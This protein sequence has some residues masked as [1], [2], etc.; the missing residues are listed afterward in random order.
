MARRVTSSKLFA[1]LGGLFLAG[2]EPP[3]VGASHAALGPAHVLFLDLDGAKVDSAA[4][5]DA[6]T[7]RSQL[8]TAAAYPAFQPSVPAPLVPAA[9]V[10]SVLIDRVRSYFL[11]FDLAVVTARPTSG[12]YAALLVGGTPASV[13]PAQPSGVAGISVVDCDEGNPRSLGFV[14]ADA[15][16]PQFGGVVSLAAAIAHEAGHGFGL[17]HVTAPLDPMYSVPQPQQTLDDLFALAFGSGIY[18][19]YVAGSAALQPERC[20][21]ADPLDNRALLFAALGA[22]VAPL[23]SP[24]SITLTFPPPLPVLPTSFP[25]EVSADDDVAVARVEVYRDLELVAVLEQAPYRTVFNLAPRDAVTLT[26]E[27]V[28]ADGQRARAVRRFDVS[29]AAP[30]YCDEA[31]P[32]VG[33]AACVG[34]FCAATELDGSVSID[35]GAD[36]AAQGVTQAGCAMTTQDRPRG[37]GELCLLVLVALLAGRR[38]WAAAKEGA[39]A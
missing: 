30:R 20:G 38:R 17:Q 9:L 18:S 8:A 6:T 28:D 39:R 21:H 13:A 31:T 11:P 34:R 36:A 12:D 27:V 29:T 5:D 26:V 15:F 22:R 33:G 10:A 7:S 35:G 16:A 23:S 37:S 2:C 14:F 3:A 1:L 19:S 24:P 25:I 4:I 32:C